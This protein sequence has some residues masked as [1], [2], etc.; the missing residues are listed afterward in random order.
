M[1]WQV[2]RFSGTHRKLSGTP[3]MLRYQ[4]RCAGSQLCLQPNRLTNTH[5]P[6]VE[7][8]CSLLP[9]LLYEG[10]SAVQG[11]AG[12]R[13][14]GACPLGCAAAACWHGETGL[15]PGALPASL[16]AAAGWALGGRG[17]QLL[18]SCARVR[19]P[20]VSFP[21]VGHVQSRSYRKRLQGMQDSCNFIPS[22]LFK[23]HSQRSLARPLALSTAPH[24]SGKT[25]LMT[26]GH[27]R[28]NTVLC[29]LL[30]KAMQEQRFSL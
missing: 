7:T 19:L 29:C 23:L 6:S 28:H 4:Q 24:H 11:R 17:A 9:S 10:S 30:Q 14:C 27:V 13:Q 15:A 18:E 20:A 12:A 26:C 8:V 5:L 3:H 16:V 1:F 2:S 25:N 21:A 22:F